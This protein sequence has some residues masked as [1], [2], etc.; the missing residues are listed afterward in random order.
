MSLRLAAVAS[1]IALCTCMNAHSQVSNFVYMI[2]IGQTSKHPAAIQTGFRLDGTKGIVTALHG[3]VDGATFSAFNEAG[4]VL[5]GLT[6]SQVDIKRDI[7]LLRSDELVQRPADGLVASPST[8]LSPG[9]LLQVLGHPIGINLYDKRVT[10]GLPATKI[11]YQLVPPASS[12]AFGKRKSP[13]DDIEVLNLDGN[14]VPGDSGA[15]VLDT[16][17]RVVGVVDGGLLGGAAAISWAIPIDALNWRDAS[18]ARGR[19]NEL[20]ELDVAD[21]FAFT[22]APLDAGTSIVVSKDGDGQYTT[23]TDAIR[24]AKAGARIVVRP[25]IYS[26]KDLTIDKSVQ[27]TGA[28]T[29]EAIIDTY[30]E[31][32]EDANVK[33]ENLTLR[34]TSSS[35]YGR[36]KVNNCAWSGWRAVSVEGGTVSIAK[37]EVHSR[38]DGDWTVSIWR[39]GSLTAQDTEITGGKDTGVLVELGSFVARNCRI[40]QN[41]VGVRVMSDSRATLSDCDLRGNGEATQR[42]RSNLQSPDNAVLIEESVLK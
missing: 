8:V 1:F 18:L 14:L 10:L 37:S 16:V 28:G 23:L 7:A 26:E 31:I 35:I 11:L 27:I 24:E 21:L 15:P 39:N 19:I 5:T 17:G 40:T 36:V 29:R 6:V 20:A 9:Q 34:N 13:E 3:V 30:L 32:T 33:L 12:E 38:A 41:G 42:R 2:R 25:G 22:E 4:D